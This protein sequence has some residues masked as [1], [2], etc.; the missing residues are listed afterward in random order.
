MS[1]QPQ[2]PPQI[3]VPRRIPAGLVFTGRL[4]HL[5]LASAVHKQTAVCCHGRRSSMKAINDDAQE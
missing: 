4:V 1:G 2:G 3:T 5:H